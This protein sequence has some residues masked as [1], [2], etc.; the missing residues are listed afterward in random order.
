[1]WSNYSII[2]EAKQKQC[3]NLLLWDQEN[4]SHFILNLKIKS[5]EEYKKERKFLSIIYY[6]MKRTQMWK[7]FFDYQVIILSAFYVIKELKEW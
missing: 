7:N 2:D 3:I 1:M 6:L 4:Y 5:Y